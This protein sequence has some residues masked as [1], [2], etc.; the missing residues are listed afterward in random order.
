MKKNQFSLVSHPWLFMLVFLILTP[1]ASTLVVLF[2]VYVVKLP[3]EALTFGFW[4]NALYKSLMVFLVAPFVLGYYRL[5]HPY[6]AYL[7][8]IRLTCWKPTLKLILLGVSC[9]VIMAVCQVVCTFIYRLAQGG[10]IDLAFLGSAFP[11]GSEFPPNSYG[12]LNATTSILEEITFRGMM[13]SLLLRFYTPPKAVLFSA[14][15]F[16]AFHLLGLLDGAAPVW[17]IGMVIWAAILGVFY[18]YITLKTGSLLPAM[19]VHFLCNLF[20]Y[21]LTAYVQDNASTLVV[22][23]YGVTLTMGVIPAVLMSLWARALTSRWFEPLSL[24]ERTSPSF[25]R[26]ETKTA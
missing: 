14:L 4:L 2:L 6:A 3:G 17:V 13:L 26:V 22:V 25:E 5:A 12:W 9:W 24:S 19:L 11:L 20:I 23:L 7:S 21:P 16:G 10:A 8:E 15:G 18:G 1:V